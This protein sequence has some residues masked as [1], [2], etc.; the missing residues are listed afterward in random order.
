M[1][2][3]V[4][5]QWKQ[6]VDK[7]GNQLINYEISNQGN[8][9][10]IKPD[11]THNYI[12]GSINTDGYKRTTIYKKHYKFHQLVAFAFIGARP[13]GLIIDHIDRDRANNN[14]DICNILRE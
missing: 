7:D 2:S 1:T 14:K 9:R 13:V 4:E 3:I 8:L 6:C 11:G 5:E 12:C 10:R